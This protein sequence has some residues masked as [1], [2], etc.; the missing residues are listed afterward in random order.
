MERDLF[1][2]GETTLARSDEDTHPLNIE[3]IGTLMQGPYPDIWKEM[4]G[5]PPRDSTKKMKRE[6]Y[7]EVKTLLHQYKETYQIRIKQID[8]NH[9]SGWNGS[10][11]GAK[12]WLKLNTDD[13]NGVVL[14]QMAKEVGRLLEKC[15]Y[16]DMGCIIMPDDY[17]PRNTD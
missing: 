5:L 2:P 14:K 15:G 4:K 11:E 13:R 9:I 10:T 6:I 16:P 12:V 17:S 1:V 3:E 7:P 8:L